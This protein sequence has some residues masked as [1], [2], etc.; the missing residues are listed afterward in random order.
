MTCYANVITCLGL[1]ADNQATASLHLLLVALDAYETAHATPSV[2]E[3]PF[4]ETL[5]RL[6]EFVGPDHPE[7]R[8]I[9]ATFG[10]R[11]NVQAYPWA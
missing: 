11:P 2:L 9:A 3:N 5:R 4:A 8:C 6:G 7:V 1:S 10:D